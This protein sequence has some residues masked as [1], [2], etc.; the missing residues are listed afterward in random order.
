MGAGASAVA[1]AAAAVVVVDMLVLM[2]AAA[3]GCSLAAA[4]GCSPA[5]AAAGRSP[6]AVVNTPGLVVV[7]V[8][9]LEQLAAVEDIRWV[10][11]GNLMLLVV[12]HNLVLEHLHS[13]VQAAGSLHIL[14]QLVASLGEILL[15]AVFG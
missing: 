7:V 2:A 8:D 10:G 6:V 4:V 12:G 1:A 3:V 9:T 14:D 5:A 13:S 15:E 11:L